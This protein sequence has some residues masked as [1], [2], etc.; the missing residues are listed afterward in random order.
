MPDIASIFGRHEFAMR[1]IHSLLGLAPVGGFMCIHLATN[2]SILDGPKTF[3]ARVDQ[4][5]S[6]GPMTLLFME[7]AFIFLPILFH[8]IVGLIIVARGRR[9]LVSYSY[10]ENFRYTLQRGSGVIAMAFI[11]WHVFHM[12][13]WIQAEW[14]VSHV[15]HPLGGGHFDPHHAAE[16]A[17][18]AIQASLAVQ[19]AYA[20]GVLACVYHFANGLWTL[21]ITW[22]A[23]TSPSA[24]RWVNIPCILVGLGL[25][26]AGLGA[27]VGMIIT[28]TVP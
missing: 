16:T 4:I 19:V 2:A 8:G 21:G 1:R 20:V 27:L 11:L 18:A 5:H 15:T 17:A 23:W 3:Q 26:A 7:W 10:L 28:K 24:Q 25:A 12:R 13:G 6:L 14:W 22:G 9:N